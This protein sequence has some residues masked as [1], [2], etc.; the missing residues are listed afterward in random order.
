M[1]IVIWLSIS[2]C[3]VLLWWHGIASICLRDLLSQN[4]VV[5]TSTWMWKFPYQKG[6]LL[7][8]RSDITNLITIR[9]LFS[10]IIGLGKRVKYH[11]W[12]LAFN[13]SSDVILTVC[14]QQK[15]LPPVKGV[16]VN[17]IPGSMIL[18]R[19]IHWSLTHSTYST[20]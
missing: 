9:W 5:G 16:L 10:I 6:Q 13:F 7:N 20:P 11:L 17:I 4:S 1:S 3:Y 12:T 8:L 19:N 18:A 14:L 2:R 15:K